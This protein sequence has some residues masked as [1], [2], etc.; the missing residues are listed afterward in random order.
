MGFL[1]FLVSAG[2]RL[3]IALLQSHALPVETDDQ[4]TVNVA[5]CD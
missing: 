4:A 1:V 5:N 3:N 2:V